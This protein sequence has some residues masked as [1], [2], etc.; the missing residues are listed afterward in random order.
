MGEIL[1]SDKLKRTEIKITAAIKKTK[2]K[3]SPDIREISLKGGRCPWRVRLGEHHLQLFQ[4]N[5]LQ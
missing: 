5:K 3:S 2:T 4:D 1:R